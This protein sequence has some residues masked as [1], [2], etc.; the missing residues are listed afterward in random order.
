ML[1]EYAEGDQVLVNPHAWKH[2]KPAPRD[3]VLLEH[4]QNAGLCIIKRIS[5]IDEEGRCFVLGD[6]PTQSTDS[7]EFGA[8]EP[9]LLLGKVVGKLA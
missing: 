1:P 3:V 9:S 7:R 5:H 4:P 2:Q 8:V 6:N